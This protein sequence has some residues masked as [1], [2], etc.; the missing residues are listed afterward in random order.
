MTANRRTAGRSLLALLL[1]QAGLLF[2]RLAQQSLWI[3]EWFTVRSAATPWNDFLSPRI[4]I[5]GRLISVWCPDPVI[6]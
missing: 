4:S 1:I 2:F 5:N 3:D 6:R